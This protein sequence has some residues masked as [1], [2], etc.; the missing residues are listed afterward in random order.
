M[1]RV[2][3]SRRVV[4]KY[5]S[6]SRKSSIEMLNTIVNN[7]LLGKI[8]ICREEAYG[9]PIGFYKNILL[10]YDVKKHTEAEFRLTDVREE[11]PTE[12]TGEAISLFLSIYPRTPVVLLDATLWDLHHEEERKKAVKQFMILINTLRKRLTELNVILVSPPIE[13]VD[14]IK[15]M[16]SII[17]INDGSIYTSVDP[18][19]VVLLDPYA[20]EEL[21]VQDVLENQ[22]FIIGLLVDDKFPR[23][24]ATYMLKLLHGI[25]CKR[26]AIKLYK[27]VIGVPKEINKIIDILLDI[28]LNGLSLENAIISN[29]S[30]DDKIRKVVHDIRKHALEGKIVDE[31]YVRKLCMVYDVNEVQF[32]KICKRIK[33]IRRLSVTAR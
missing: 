16:D 8:R 12:I 32:E 25:D 2:V 14:L 6:P 23:P 1:S 29:M 11:C 31:Q 13:L 5:L 3:I 9:T 22:Y 33:R 17:E 28:R 26:R 30:I 27:S 24:Y 20:H 7:M 10:L 21:S 4:K 15:K 18:S 19:K